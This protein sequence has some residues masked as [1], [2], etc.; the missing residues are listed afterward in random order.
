M[1]M[2]SRS[3]AASVAQE[4]VDHLKLIE[5]VKA[6]QTGQKEM[7]DAIARLNDRMH[8]IEADMKVLRSEIKLEALQEAQKVVWAV[9]S[10]LNDRVQDLAVKVGVFEHRSAQQQN[11]STPA[12]NAPQ[13]GPVILDDSEVQRGS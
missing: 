12:L 13:P 8:S 1:H 5:N 2:F 9:Q 7:A 3:R 4:V 6:L 10:G 11:R